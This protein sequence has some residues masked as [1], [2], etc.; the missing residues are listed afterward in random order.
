MILFSWLCCFW[1]FSKPVL[2]EKHNHH[3]CFS[4]LLTSFFCVISSKKSPILVQL[5]TC[6][7][8]DCLVERVVLKSFYFLPFIVL[9]LINGLSFINQILRTTH[10]DFYASVFRFI[11]FARQYFY[12]LFPAFKIYW[13]ETQYFCLWVTETYS[14]L[15]FYWNKFYW[16]LLSTYLI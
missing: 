4:F 10:Y 8:F 14:D 12:I 2:I 3:H 11:V 9:L 6:N 5:F 16:F 15:V 1:I 7:H 13:L